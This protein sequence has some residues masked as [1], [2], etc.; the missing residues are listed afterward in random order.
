MPRGSGRTGGRGGPNPSARNSAPTDI[1]DD[2]W[3]QRIRERTDARYIDLTKL[4]DRRRWHPAR[5]G[6]FT[7]KPLPRGLR[8]RPRIVI[9]PEGHRL[10]RHQTYGGR[11]SVRGLLHAWKFRRRAVPF[12]WMRMRPDEWAY[13]SVTGHR[14]HFGTDGLSRRVG[15]ALPWQVVVC[16]RRQRRRQ[17]MHALGIAGRRGVGAGKRR[18]MDEYTGVR[19]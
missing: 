16:V 1:F 11:Y 10:A 17:V 3:L 6:P 13:G 8:F 19:C 5:L 4:E 9:V 15:F 14:L 7:G 12:A 18:H 2:A